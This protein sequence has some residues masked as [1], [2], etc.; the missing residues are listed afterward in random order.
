[1]QTCITSC[2]I[3]FKLDTTF[4]THQSHLSFSFVLCIVWCPYILFSY[5]SHICAFCPF[6]AL[7]SPLIFLQQHLLESLIQAKKWGALLHL[8]TLLFICL[9][10]KLHKNCFAHSTFTL[11]FM[12]LLSYSMPWFC[13]HSW[14]I[15]FQIFGSLLIV[16][17]P[18]F[19]SLYDV[20]IVCY[21]FNIYLTTL[22]DV[23]CMLFQSICCMRNLPANIHST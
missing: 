8:F 22:F 10:P 17:I 2:F 4:T 12:F 14:F 7:Y 9:A 23:Y 15:L 13:S 21:T 1:M 16:A 19:N 5:Y 6:I 20:C 11:S 3:C 18:L